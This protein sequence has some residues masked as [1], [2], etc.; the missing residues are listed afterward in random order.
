[1]LHPFELPLSSG[2]TVG[3]TILTSVHD[4]GIDPMIVDIGA[5]NGMF[6]LPT[7]YTSAARFVGF[8]PNEVEFR[9]LVEEQTDAMMVFDLR[10]PFKNKKYFSCAVWDKKEERDFY[11]TKGP[12]ACTMMGHCDPKVTDRM[13]LDAAIGTHNE[14]YRTQHTEVLKQEKMGCDSLDNMLGGDVV[15]FLKLDTE[16][17]ELR[18]LQGAATLLAEHKILFI[19]TEFVNLAY[20]EEHPVFGHLHGYLN[21]RGYRLIGVDHNQPGYSRS[22][23]PIPTLVDRRARYAGDAYFM[24]DPDRTEMD[25]LTRHR[26]AAIC[27]ALGFLSMAVSL[28]R[29]AAIL[30][31]V[32]I[33]EIETV[34]SRIPIRKKLVH[35]WREFPYAVQRWLSGAGLKI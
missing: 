14:S 27:L 32:Q 13:F 26:L 16:G 33:T 20:Y 17:A 15:D 34:L 4:K 21:D 10:P 6:F 23:T 11:I 25:P 12:G 7:G 29:D 1:M 31:A 18:I 22:P 9:K 24:L 35:G 30:S 2:Q 8:E 28:L 19:K 5:R 3:K